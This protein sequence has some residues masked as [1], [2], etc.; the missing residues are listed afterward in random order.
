MFPETQ[1]SFDADYNVDEFNLDEQLSDTDSD[2]QSSEQIIQKNLDNI[3]LDYRIFT[4][5]YDEITKA[6]KLELSFFHESSKD[7]E[8]IVLSS[9]SR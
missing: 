8:L 9:T 6:E 3:N 5:Q 4:T 7:A 2:E 1:A